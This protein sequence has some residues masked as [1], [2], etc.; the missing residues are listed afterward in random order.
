ML[1]VEAGDWRLLIEDGGLPDLYQSY[2][3][4]AVF[5]DRVV[6]VKDGGRDLFVAIKAK[7]DRA[8]AS[9]LWP[10][11]VITQRYQDAQGTLR[12]GILLV[13]EASMLFV[14][15]GECLLGY[16]LLSRKRVFEDWTECGFF[17][18][19]RQGDYILMSAELEFAVWKVTGE[20][21]WSTFVEPPWSWEVSGMNVK[22]D[23]MGRRK[24]L[25]LETGISAD[26]Q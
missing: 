3:G 11:M 18:W 10:E 4:N 13:P 25:L 17:G 7:A 20:K 12:P 8:G 9:H 14:G 24:A 5:V 1:T 19:S 16:N 21:L 6:P 2:V 23:V 22:L 15:A 26:G